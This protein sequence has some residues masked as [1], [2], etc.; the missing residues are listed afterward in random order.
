MRN[1]WT[2]ICLVDSPIFINSLSPFQVLVVSGVLLYFHFMSI[3]SSCWQTVY[4]LIRRCV[5]WRLIWGYTGC[6]WSDLGLHWLHVFWS[7]ATLVACVLIWGYTGCL[8]SDLGLHWLPVFWSGA[9]LVACVLIWCYTGCLCSDLGL[10]WLP[11]F[12]SGA[13]LVACVLIWGYTGC[14]CSDLG[15]HWLPVFWS[16]ATLVAYVLILG[17]TGCLCSDLGLHWLPMF[18]SGATLVAYVLIWGYTVCLCSDLGLHW[19]LMFWSVATL[20]AY[21]LIWGYTVC[22]CSDLGLTGFLCSDQGLHCLP[23]FEKLDARHNGVNSKLLKEPPH[24]KT[25]K[26]VCAPSE[27]SDQPGHPPS[28]IRVFAVRMNKDW[29]LSYS[30]CAQWRLIRLGWSESSLGA[31]T[32]CWFCHEAAQISLIML[33]LLDQTNWKTNYF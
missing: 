29:V 25:N 9:T 11:V 24:A 33:C 4:T 28:L 6:L 31:Q 1:F 26:I 20:V 14:M 21:V 3:R 18:W 30:L 13:T 10:H 15:L 5:L 16:G 2:H 7:G 17:Y 23:M 22:L 12:W 19:L 27:D 32:F 8:C